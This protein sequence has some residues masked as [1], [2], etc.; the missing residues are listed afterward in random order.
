MNE[1]THI[2]VVDDNKENLRVVSSF[3]QA[4]GYKMAL[5]LDG[6]NALKLLETT[7]IDL[8]L[9]DI[10]MPG[11]D[12]FKVCEV[13]KS[14]EATKDI[15]VIFLTAKNQTN[16]IVKGFK[17]GGV[18]YILKP[19]VKEELYARVHNH[20][21]LKLAIDQLK[22]YAEGSTKDRDFYMKVLLDLSKTIYQK[23]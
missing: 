16:D 13:L 12:G 8:I 1:N 2:L 15:P 19:F 10:M 6:E 9:L 3:L 5:A 20:V 11:M 7:K 4:K 17:L 18:D 21:R 14:K 23:D 22:K